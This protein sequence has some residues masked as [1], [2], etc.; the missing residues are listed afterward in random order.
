M[1][2]RSWLCL[3]VLV[4]LCATP[5][6]LATE[7]S[8][9]RV[10]SLAD[11]IEDIYP[12]L[13][14][15]ETYPLETFAKYGE[16]V[17][18]PDPPTDWGEFQHYLV[19]VPLTTCRETVLVASYRGTQFLLPEDINKLRTAMA[20]TDVASEAFMRLFVRSALSNE[21]DQINGFDLKWGDWRPLPQSELIF[22]ARMRQESHDGIVRNWYFALRDGQIQAV[23][24]DVESTPQDVL[25]ESQNGCRA[26]LLPGS[27]RSW[28]PPLSSLADEADQRAS[29]SLNHQYYT[30]R[31]NG[32]YQDSGFLSISLTGFQPLSNVALE[33]ESKHGGFPLVQTNVDINILGMGSFEWQPAPDM[34]SDLIERIEAT[35]ND[36]LG[37]PVVELLPDFPEYPAGPKPAVEDLRLVEDGIEPG[38]DIRIFYCTGFDYP[39][40][41]TPDAYADAVA[42]GLETAAQRHDEWSFPLSDADDIYE[43]IVCV[44]DSRF[45]GA[46]TNNASAFSGTNRKVSIYSNYYTWACVSYPHF[47][48]ISWEDFVG[49]AMFHEFHHGCQASFPPVG[50]WP[51]SDQGDYMTEGMARFVPALPYPQVVLADETMYESNANAYLIGGH[52]NPLSSHSYD[53]CIFWNFIYHNARGGSEAERMAIFREIYAEAKLQED[54]GATFLEG[55]EA[56]ITAGLAAGGATATYRSFAAAFTRFWVANYLLSTASEGEYYD[57]ADFYDDPGNIINETYDGTEHDFVHNLPNNY[58]ADIIPIQVTSAD[59]EDFTIEFKGRSS[60]TDSDE[61]VVGIVSIDE[62]MYVRRDWL[63]LDADQ[64][65][66]AKVVSVGHDADDRVTLVV[67]RVDTETS[68]AN[69]DYE[70][71]L[72]HSGIDAVVCLDRSGSMSGSYIQNA[73]I[74]AST[75]V[76]LMNIGDMIGVTSFS[77]SATTNYPLTLITGPGIKSA[78]QNAISGIGTGGYTSIGAGLL[79]S[80]GQFDASGRENA[81]WAMLLLSDGYENRPPYV[82]N[83]LPSIPAQTD[84]YTIALGPNSDQNLLS[85]IANA[86][87]GQFFMAP[88]PDDLQAIY[89]NLRGD[90]GGAVLVLFEEGYIAPSPL[91]SLDIRPDI[92]VESGVRQ[93]TFSISWATSQDLDLRLIDPA[94]TYIDPDYAAGDPNIEYSSWNSYEYYVIEDPLPGDWTM[95]THLVSGSGT[96]YTRSVSV[97]GSLLM[98]SYTNK[99]EYYLGE[100]IVLLTRLQDGPFPILDAAVTVE[101]ESGFLAAG[102]MKEAQARRKEATR[103][104]TTEWEWDEIAEALLK[105]TTYTL[106]DDGVHNDGEP[107]DGLYGGEIPPGLVEDTYNLTF[108]ASGLTI[109]GDPFTRRMIGSFV[110][111]PDVAGQAVC[112]PEDWSV[113]WNPAPQGFVRFV[114]GDL[115]FGH[116]VSEIDVPTIALED[117]LQPHV[118]PVILPS[119]PGFTGEVM[120]MI[121]DRYEALELLGN[122]QI[123]DVRWPRVTG[124][125]ASGTQFVCAA[126]V[127][128]VEYPAAPLNLEWDGGHG[129]AW[130]HESSIPAAFFS[131]YGGEESGF[132]IDPEHRLGTTEHLVF[133][134]PLG[135]SHPFYVV[136]A[137]DD[138]GHESNPSNEVGQGAVSGVEWDADRLPLAVGLWSRGPVPASHGQVLAFSLPEDAPVKIQVCSV[139]GRTI[140]TITDGPYPA[141]V[142]EV[143]WDG[144]DDHGRSVAS[145]IYLIE[146]QAGPRSMSLKTTV[147]QR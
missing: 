61:W 116:T 11:L 111:S 10:L 5:H 23:V 92:P 88:G 37:N 20:E 2:A 69:G 141:G 67:C 82:A 54:G 50:S 134:I 24:V 40:S 59:V 104:A 41:V 101:L 74:A 117:D 35:G 70:V 15:P 47:S 48:S 132:P 72:K 29:V 147:I 146:L 85:Q 58:N 53:F 21:Y 73:R 109:E 66:V 137:T 119:F 139:T 14:D 60:P 126:H 46:L 118:E 98:E 77:S 31:E 34:G 91:A 78:A 16:V 75:F 32:V 138:A 95:E 7:N 121:F 27:S 64:E 136:T 49:R 51:W 25:R 113:D 42:T 44:T 112:V 62:N 38:F 110:L 65:G 22:T 63:T 87:G 115:A 28:F 99:E 100:P 26:Y 97:L 52:N 13:V 131:V 56:A 18:L 124:H 108:D 114:I 19:S 83:V 9:A 45:H 145:G 135:S 1:H 106:Y 120:I 84:I 129:L 71:T 142:H 68:G 107:N 102:N 33:I 57:P 79:Q 76:G 133:E 86:T 43:A 30:I 81:P 144:R 36:S 93:V 6:T 122:V 128:I 17:L 96:A 143:C 3:G 4:L 140:R 90:L 103:T 125:F 80:Q 55:G 8:H 89:M 127:E 39:S 130:E 105:R 12:R 123:G 94:G